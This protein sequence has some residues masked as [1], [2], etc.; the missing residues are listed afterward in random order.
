MKSLF[1]MGFLLLTLCTIYAFPLVYENYKLTS[2]TPK[3]RIISERS[4]EDKTI[5]VEFGDFTGDYPEFKLS[6]ISRAPLTIVWDLCAFIDSDGRSQSVLR[7]GIPFQNR[8]NTIPSTIVI[9]G[10]YVDEIMVPV[11]SIQ[12]VDGEW[13]ATS[14]IPRIANKTISVVLTVEQHGEQ[15]TYIFGFESVMG[16]GEVLVESGSFIMGDDSLAPFN[17]QPAHRVSFTYDF[18]IGKYEVTFDEYDAFCEETG[19][20]KPNDEGWGR[21]ARPVI[22]ISWWDAIDYC[23]WLSEKEGLQKVYDKDG[24]LL[25]KYGHITTDPS[26]VLGYRLPTEAELEYA[27]KGG[28]KSKGYSYSGSDSVGDIAWYRENSGSKT[29]KIGKKTPNELGLY[30]MSGN[31]WEWCSDWFG[32]YSD[33]AETNP[34]GD[35]GYNRVIRGGGWDSSAKITHV[36]FRFFNTPT[37]TY[38]YLG[39]RIARTAP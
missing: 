11:G 14:S 1:L 6:N 36:S 2:V 22:N 8:G 4:Y 5:R 12:F 20:S 9:P 28:N 10:A 37:D 30:D 32:I 26:I 39:F 23:N 15:T 17:V 25:D 21:G 29:Q 19:R 16:S 13:K 33:S 7:R 3:G 31:V 35:I 38:Y 27:A 24:N 18:Y 34:Y